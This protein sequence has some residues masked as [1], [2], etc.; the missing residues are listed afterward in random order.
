[1]ISVRDSRLR[2]NFFIA[3]LKDFDDKGTV[4]Q[5]IILKIEM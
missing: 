1:M 4:I 3:S 5:Q 2:G